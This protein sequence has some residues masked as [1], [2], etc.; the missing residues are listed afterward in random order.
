M[1]RSCPTYPPPPGPNRRPPGSGAGGPGGGRPEP[2]GAPG[3]P[4]PKVRIIL[5]LTHCIYLFIDLLSMAIVPHLH[6]FYT[7]S[8]VTATPLPTIRFRTHRNFKILFPH[9][10]GNVLL[11]EALLAQP[12]LPLPAA[13][14]ASAGGEAAVRADEDVLPPDA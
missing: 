4:A 6:P 10:V 9:Q 7:A 13:A 1:T 2:G 12:A 5:T 14:A 11:A 3:T 8:K